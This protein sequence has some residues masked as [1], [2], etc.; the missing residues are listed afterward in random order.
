MTEGWR[1]R[2][3]SDRGISMGFQDR[4]SIATQA[5]HESSSSFRDS[6]CAYGSCSA[7]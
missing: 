5:Q 7:C 4:D 3:S 1:R 6:C 2:R